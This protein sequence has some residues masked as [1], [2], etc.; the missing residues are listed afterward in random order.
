E[1]AIADVQRELFAEVDRNAREALEGDD[2]VVA[3]DRREAVSVGRVEAS[4]ANADADI[5]IERA[6]AVEVEQR[7]DH[8]RPDVNVAVVEHVLAEIIV[9]MADLAFE[10]DAIAEG[11]AKPEV[12]S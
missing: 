6:A 9:A 5:R 7:V 10:A 3:R 4:A 8:R 12:L 2:R 11:V 1:V